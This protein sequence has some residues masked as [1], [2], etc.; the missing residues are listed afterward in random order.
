MLLEFTLLNL[1]PHGVTDAAQNL[2]QIETA[3]PVSRL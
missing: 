1:S 2:G 3:L